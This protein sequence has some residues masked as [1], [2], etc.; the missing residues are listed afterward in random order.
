MPASG[1]FHGGCAASPGR[2]ELPS[3]GVLHARTPPRPA[4]PVLADLARLRAGTA[5][6]PVAGAHSREGRTGHRGPL[7]AARAGTAG[8]GQFLARPD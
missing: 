5:A 2:V 4:R 8:P 7:A 1:R 6:G 3:A